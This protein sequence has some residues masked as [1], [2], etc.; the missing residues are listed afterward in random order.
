MEASAHLVWL[1]PLFPLGAAA[2]AALLPSNASRLSAALAMGAMGLSLAM[3]LGA[4]AATLGGAPEGAGAYRWVWN[5]EWFRLGTDA[6][7]LGVVLDPL[8]ALMLVGIELMLNAAN[9]SFIAFWRH[10]PQPDAATGILFVL[11]AI[12]V[13]AAEASV[14]LALVIALFRHRRSTDPGSATTLRG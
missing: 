12:A 9:L 10:G 2:V 6:V 3:A 1:A 11:F 7:R 8:A 4:F 14:G 5:F 13:A